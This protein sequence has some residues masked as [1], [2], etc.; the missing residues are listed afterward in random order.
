MRDYLTQLIFF[1]QLQFI[2]NNFVYSD[3]KALRQPIS[4]QD[5]ATAVLNVLKL[6][7]TK[8]KMY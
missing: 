8:G 3:L 5:I 4:I 1:Q 6:D 7:E 2:G